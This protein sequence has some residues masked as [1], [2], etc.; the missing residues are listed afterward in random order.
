MRY[1]VVHAQWYLVC[2]VDCML[3]M[4]CYRVIVWYGMLWYVEI[5]YV[6]KV[7]VL[8]YVLWCCVQWSFSWFCYLRVFA[9]HGVYAR[10]K[11]YSLFFIFCNYL[12]SLLCY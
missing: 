10:V 5:C 1:V 6:I 2:C 8:C 3:V 11:A 9:L 12:L 4:R 7:L